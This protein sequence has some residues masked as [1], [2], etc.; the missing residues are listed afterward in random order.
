LKTI[1]VDA[2][3]LDIEAGT[4]VTLL[5]PGCGKTTTLRMIAT[6]KRK[7][8]PCADRREGRHPS[9]AE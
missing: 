2:V 7:P 9:A 6:L 5:A 3:T 8:G 1:A 4:L